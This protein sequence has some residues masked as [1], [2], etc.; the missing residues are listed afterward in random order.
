LKL[1][2][3]LRV[4]TAV[5]ILAST[6]TTKGIDGGGKLSPSVEPAT[7]PAMHVNVELNAGCLTKPIL[8]IDCALD[9][10]GNVQHC[11]KTRVEFRK[12]CGTVRL[13]HGE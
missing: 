6:T 5:L 10:S 2:T 8:L 4:K 3:I 11:A 12:N 13:S 7:R 1:L 9:D